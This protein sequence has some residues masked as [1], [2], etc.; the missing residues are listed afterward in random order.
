LAGTVD[1]AR[2]AWLVTPWADPVTSILRLAC[3]LGSGILLVEAAD[4]RTKD[5]GSAGVAPE[6]EPGSDARGEVDADA[7]AVK[8]K[9]PVLLAVGSR[10]RS[11]RAEESDA[12]DNR[13][14]PDC[15]DAVTAGVD[16]GA[17]AVITAIVPGA[18]TG[19]ADEA[20]D[21]TP[22]VGTLPLPVCAKE[23]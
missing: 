22:T 17:T 3:A 12:A 15:D 10:A 9:M 8:D 13:T 11:A 4:G 23:N 2:F 19:G 6:P 7:V 21:E 1:L 18:A 20:I 16:V 5:D 14:A